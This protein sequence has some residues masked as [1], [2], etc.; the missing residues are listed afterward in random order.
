MIIAATGQ[1]ATPIPPSRATETE[2]QDRKEAPKSSRMSAA[3]GD[4]HRESSSWN[5]HCH[6]LIKLEAMPWTHKH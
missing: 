5:S 6:E 1:G 3:A 4:A 2:S